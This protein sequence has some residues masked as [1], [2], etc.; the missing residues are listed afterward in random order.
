MCFISSGGANLRVTHSCL[1][2]PWVGFGAMGVYAG[3]FNFISP[4]YNPP[5]RGKTPTSLPDLTWC[6]VPW[7][8][9]NTTLYPA[10]HIFPTLHNGQEICAT[11]NLEEIAEFPDCSSRVISPLFGIGCPFA[12]TKQPPALPPAPSDTLY[13][14]ASESSTIWSAA[15]DSRTMLK[16]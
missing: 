9:S 15:P 11:W 16:S 7:P 4:T 14:G 10:S 13:P 2:K 3:F 6:I 1:R 5:F 12:A 8:D